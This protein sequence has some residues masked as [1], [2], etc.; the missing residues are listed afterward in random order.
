LRAIR[1]DADWN[2]TLQLVDIRYLEERVAHLPHG[3][4]RAALVVEPINLALQDEGEQDQIWRRYRQLLGS[5]TGPISV[6]STSR[7][8]PGPSDWPS[9]PPDETRRQALARQ[10]HEFCRRLVKGRM[11]QRQQHLLVVWGGDRAT[12]L[13]GLAGYLRRGMGSRVGGPPVAVGGSEVGL[14]QRCEVI[15]AG[16]GRLGVRSRRLSDGDWLDN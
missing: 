4:Q 3:G 12:S 6:Y 8:D 7:P 2:S 15:S 16:L 10:D 9:T 14:Q 5:L 11:V 1:R 13:S